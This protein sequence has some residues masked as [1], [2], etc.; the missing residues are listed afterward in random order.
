MTLR[1][2]ALHAND[3]QG[4]LAA[5]GVLVLADELCGPARLGWEHAAGAARLEVQGVRTAQDLADM[6]SGRASALAA[7]DGT[8][9][10]PSIARF[11]FLKEG[12]RGS[13]P[14]RLSPRAAAGVA[15]EA[16]SREV[17]GDRVYANW[18]T[19]LVN[20][21]APQKEDGEERKLTP[22]DAP[23]GQQTLASSFARSLAAVVRE[24][25]QLH[26]ALTGWR[27]VDGYAGANL[28]H[29]AER[30]ASVLPS[31]SGTNFAAPGP[32]WLALMSTPLLRLTGDGRRG[33]ATLWQ[34]PRDE[35]GRR[36]LMVWPAWDEMLRREAIVTLIEHPALELK[37]R[38]GGGWRPVDTGA[39]AALG[40]SA[41]WW[42]ARRRLGKSAGPLGGARSAWIR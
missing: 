19:G 10:H 20:Q 12:T 2:P 23:A 18:F 41:V 30:D 42:A 17:Q 34:S 7:G 9:V 16:A 25:D 11:P 6:L 24:P 35:A 26:R 29:R 8:L 22:L 1:L 28:D 31:A 15:R 13:D 4:F 27:R 38:K 36:R 33:G 39:L 37:P 32:T 14:M 5:L 21:C 3:A 40:V